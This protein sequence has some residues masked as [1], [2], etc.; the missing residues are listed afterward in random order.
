MCVD[1][2]QG[3]VAIATGVICALPPFTPN[4]IADEFSLSMGEGPI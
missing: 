4:D 1:V 3:I 2:R